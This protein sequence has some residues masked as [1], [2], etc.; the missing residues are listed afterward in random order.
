MRME[1]VGG[2]TLCIVLCTT[3]FSSGELSLG[4]LCRCSS[5][6]IFAAAF[7]WLVHRCFALLGSR[8]G[9]RR[10]HLTGWIKCRCVPERTLPS[11]CHRLRLIGPWQTHCGLGSIIFTLNSKSILFCILAGLRFYL[12]FW[13]CTGFLICQSWTFIICK[14]EK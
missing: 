11:T 3:A 4:V 9:G 13:I 1:R 8:G 7:I 5:C 14:M 2:K 10:R 6:R 12:T